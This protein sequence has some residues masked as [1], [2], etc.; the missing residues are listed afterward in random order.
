MTDQPGSDPFR[1]PFQP[2]QQPSYPG[3]QPPPVPPGGPVPPYSQP[4]YSQ[5]PYSQPPY[6]G[7]Q[8][9]PGQPS[10]PPGY[11]QPP[12]YLPPPGYSQPAGFGFDG[13]GMQPVKKKRSVWKWLLGILVLLV[14]LVGGCSYWLFQA[15][16]APVDATNE[17][18]AAVQGDDWTRAMTLVDTSPACFGENAEADLR[19]YFAGESIESYSFISSF[20]TSTNGETTAEVTGDV[21]FSSSGDVG[22]GVKMR[23]TDDQWRLCGI[24]SL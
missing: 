14:L 1:G 5:P 4:P 9:P 19:S 6:G 12:D 15:V 23:Q 16:S 20:V 24:T 13:P 22:M 7:G 18:M 21:T 8:P 2:P 17:F 11:N 10:Y 3:Q